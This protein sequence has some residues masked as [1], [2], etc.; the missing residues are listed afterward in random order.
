MPSQTS[1]KKNDSNGYFL[2]F[3]GANG[4]NINVYYNKGVKWE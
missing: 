2:E 4:R 1:A 3:S